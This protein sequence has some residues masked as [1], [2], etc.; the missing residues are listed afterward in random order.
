MIDIIMITIIIIMIIVITIMIMIILLIMLMMIIIM[1]IIIPNRMCVAR[2]KYDGPRFTGV[3]VKSRGVRFHRTR[4]LK[5]YYFNRIPPTSH[6]RA[7]Q[8]ASPGAVQN[9]WTSSGQP[10]PRERRLVDRTDGS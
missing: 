10:G 1:I 2:N 5:R 6:L 8:D 7:K 4:D 3:R 9:V